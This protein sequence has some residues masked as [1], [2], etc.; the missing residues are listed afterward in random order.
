V[1]SVAGVHR[2]SRPSSTFYRDCPVLTAEP[3][4]LRDARIELVSAARIVL[5]NALDCLGLKLRKK[6]RPSRVEE[7]VEE[8]A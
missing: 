7:E 6:C 8:R 1:H 5:Q 4:S 2:T 3:A